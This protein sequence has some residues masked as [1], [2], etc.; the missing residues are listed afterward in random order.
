MYFS[1]QFNGQLCYHCEQPIHGDGLIADVIGEWGEGATSY[2]IHCYERAARKIIEHAR[3]LP[4]DRERAAYMQWLDS[5][6]ARLRG[7]REAS[8]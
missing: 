3:Y 4:D 7:E 8:E 6:V 1:D 5:E 2:H